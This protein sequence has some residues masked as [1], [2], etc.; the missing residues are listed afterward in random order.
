MKCK[1]PFYLAIGIATYSLFNLAYAEQLILDS[2]ISRVMVYPDSA[3]VTRSATISIPAGESTIV[4]TGLPLALL[5]SSLRVTGKA[6]ADVKLGSVEL[7]KKINREAVQKSEQD[8]RD[9]IEEKNDQK[10]G[11]IDSLQQNKD[12][13]SYIRTM[14]NGHSENE[15]KVS[16]NRYLQLPLEQWDQAW[17]T[18]ATATTSTQEKI[19]HASK[20]I[21]QLDKTILQLQRQLNQ[22]ATHHQASRTAVLAI[23]TD[24]ATELAL[25][26]RYQ[27][28]GARWQPVYDADLDT[29][30]GKV[31]LKSLAQITQRTGE[32]WDNV[33]IR[34]STLRPSARSQ[35]PSLNPWVIDFIPEYPQYSNSV[36]MKSNKLGVSQEMNESVMADESAAMS[37]PAPVMAKRA[38]R[39]EVSRVAIA[40]F[41]AEYNVPTKVSLK[42]G[43]DKRRVTLQSQTL[44]ASV[45]LASVPRLDPRA[46]LIAKMHYKGEIPLLA[47]AVVLHRDGSFIGNGYLAM[48]QT[49]EEIKLSFGEDDQVKIRFIPDPDQKGEDGLF[50]GK[51]KTINRNYHFSVV[52]QHDKAYHISFSDRIPVSA[53]E[54][55]KVTL[56][57]AKPTRRNEEDKQGITVWERNLVPK[58]MIKLEYGYEVTYPED[59][60]VQGL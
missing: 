60:R 39:T 13:L 4:L 25:S 9:K 44:D 19:R 18:L 22:V 53:N 7:Q 59:K 49:G 52:N 5:E 34:L 31:A 57:G 40:N 24:K 33:N 3:M 56:N 55:I 51:R 54:D 35:L 27:I 37:M 1:Q 36:K 10:Q 11:L 48:H 26:L 8:L 6:V 58:K 2:V 20:E 47:G 16:S 21:K 32:D 28:R 50:F 29:E 15:K 41:S 12:Q 45:S 17:Q 23:Q 42:S 30:S 14:V 43:S 38:M 46:M